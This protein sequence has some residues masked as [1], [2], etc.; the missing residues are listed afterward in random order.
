MARR[1]TPSE[2]LA[3]NQL[4]SEWPLIWLYE[5]EGTEADT[6]HRFVN[7]EE[8]VVYRGN[9]FYRAAISHG[10]VESNGR[11]DT[12]SIDFA[13]GGAFELFAAIDAADGF[14]GRFC[15][16]TLI[17]FNL[18]HDD[19]AG[20]AFVG[21]IAGC[22]ISDRDGIQF[23]AA[24]R[25][26]QRARLPRYRYTRRRCRF[27]FGDGL[28]GFEVTAAGAGF[29]TCPGYTYEACVK[30]GADEDAR[31]LEVMHPE[32]FGGHPGIPKLRRSG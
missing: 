23:T 25:S 24:A 32:R 15:R 31:G 5:V 29:T 17:P 10:G 13:I 22:S 2:L 19:S 11:G 18:V 30:V 28:C 9:T 4:E 8:D 20:A 14:T 12:P 16:I 3:K 27:L 21:E 1:L 6:M 26:L 7:Y